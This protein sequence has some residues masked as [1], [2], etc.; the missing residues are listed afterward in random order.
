[1]TEIARLPDLHPPTEP[2]GEDGRLAE[3]EARLRATEKLLQ[4]STAKLRMALE[5]GKLGSF[6]WDMLTDE[7]VM[8]LVR[9]GHLRLHRDPADLLPG[10]PGTVPSPRP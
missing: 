3:M 2:V 9:P 6:E 10:I 5:I 4:H 7:I 1:M 8:E